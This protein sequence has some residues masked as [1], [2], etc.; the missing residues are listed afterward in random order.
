M[1]QQEQ[2][3]QG[4]VGLEIADGVATLVFDRPEARNAMTWT[5]YEQ[6]GAHCRQLTDSE[7]VRVAVLRGAGHEA[8]VAGTDIH[9]FL[10]FASGDDGVDYE[11][12]IDA[13]I[14]LI[15]KLPFPTIAVIEGW[16]VGGGLAIATACDFRIATPGAKFG[17]PIARTLGNM[18][19]PLNMA[20]LRQAWG[21]QN[22]RRMLLLA[23]ILNAEEA[24]ACG[25]LHEVAA[26]DAID[27]AV[28]QLIGRLRALAPVTQ[29]S[30]KEALRRLTLAGVPE[31]DD[32]IR[33]CYGS[34][35]FR[36]GVRAFTERRPP[37]WQGR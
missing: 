36:E 23:H 27:A 30:S 37:V 32:L 14:G 9:Q 1:T 10:A 6:L 26:P 22:V 7:G 24:Q 13:G 29:S 4:R 15:E 17:V 25:F 16:A 33:A 11:E 31:M 19:S 18:L 28:G 34:D 2:A 3:A 21:H 35:D 20:R 8:F 5:M 12:K